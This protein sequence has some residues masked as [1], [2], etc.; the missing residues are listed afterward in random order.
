MN[1]AEAY[2]ILELSSNA[3]PEEAK[4]KYREL[5]KKYHPDVNKEPDAENKF[6]KINEAYQCVQS[7][8]GTD[9]EDNVINNSH[10][11][12]FGG[13]RI[14]NNEPVN[15]FCEIDF[16]ESV[17]G[18]KK[19]FKFNRKIKCTECDGNG[20]YHTHNG[21][22]KCGGKGRVITKQGNIIFARTCDKCL[23]V[24]PVTSCNTCSATGI[25]G[26]EA[27]V[28]VN[29]PGGVQTGSILRLGGMGNFLGNFMGMEQYTDAL[30]HIKVIADADFK[31]E[32]MHVISNVTVS[33]LEAIQGCK[34]TVKTIL[35]SQDVDI[36]PLSKNNQEVILPHFGVNK[37]GNQRVI[38]NVNYPN[39]IDKLVSSLK[40]IE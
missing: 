7:G 24:S 4:K 3:S 26:A 35:G 1:L 32:G 17:L 5:T 13:Q 30:L 27:S 21:C 38:I 19:E 9:R 12:P 6:K 29:I 16:K 18:C 22:D 15:L 14:I 40:E 10:Y 11:N 25:L 20:E 34:K 33:L 28:D 23:G 31:L 39:D 36:K 2:K 8:R 37:V